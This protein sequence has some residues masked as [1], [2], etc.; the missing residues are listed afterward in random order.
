[1]CQR[2]TFFNFIIL[3]IPGH[4]SP[5]QILIEKNKE[6]LRKELNKLETNFAEGK[7][8]I[9]SLENTLQKRKNSK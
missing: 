6:L 2:V 7:K 4:E 1:M 5:L 8:K 3:Y 9:N